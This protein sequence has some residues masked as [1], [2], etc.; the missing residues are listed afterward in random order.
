MAAEYAL[1]KKKT[2]WK[3]FFILLKWMILS[4]DSY[5]QYPKMI[6]YVEAVSGF[7]TKDSV[8]CFEVKSEMIYGYFIIIHLSIKSLHR[9]SYWVAGLS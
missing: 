8:K 7:I 4:L 2:H 3:V 5:I 1:K 9:L 6:L